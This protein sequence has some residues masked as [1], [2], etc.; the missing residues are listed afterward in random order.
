MKNHLI[1]D[2]HIISRDIEKI[3]LLAR[4]QADNG[5]LG[6]IKSRGDSISITCPFHK[7]GKEN[8]PSCSIYIGEDTNIPWGTFHCFTC[9]NKG[10]LSKFLAKTFERS[11]T[12][13]KEW[14][15]KNFTEKVISTNDEVLSLVE[16]PIEFI[17]QKREKDTLELNENDLDTLYQHWHPYMEQRH[18][19]K[20]IAEKFQLRY[21]IKSKCIV[22]PVRDIKGRLIFLT[23]R[24]V[25]G[26]A[27][28]IDANVEKCVYLLNEAKDSTQ[29]VVCEGQIDALVSWSY[30]VP[31]VA[32]FGAGTTEEQIKELNKTNILHYILMY[33]N[34]EAGRKGA[35]RFKKLIRKDVFITDIV[36]PK[37]KDVADCSKEE[38]R[39][40][41]K[42]N[43][44][45]LY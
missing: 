12:F 10:G 1:I 16:S 9:G 39:N 19:S 6:S 7:D 37:G 5:K 26:K 23:K 36:M 41:L 35:S 22:F 45:L 25:K 29:V 43:N 18:I 44:I 32:L 11:E 3:L 28:Y 24:S 8:K 14:L 30:G 42:D 13:A 33:D 38:F 21:D 31:A 4:T 17:T 34:D 2:N 27:F 15:K 40:I 20:E